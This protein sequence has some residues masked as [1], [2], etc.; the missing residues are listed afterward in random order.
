VK[1]VELIQKL[2]ALA[3][4]HGNVDVIIDDVHYSETRRDYAEINEPRASS[5]FGSEVVIYL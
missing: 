2:A 4:E 3:A 1:V 5:A